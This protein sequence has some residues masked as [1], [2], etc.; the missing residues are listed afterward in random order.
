MAGHYQGLSLAPQRQL[1]RALYTVIISAK[2]VLQ[3]DL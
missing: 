2:T 3:L 1:C